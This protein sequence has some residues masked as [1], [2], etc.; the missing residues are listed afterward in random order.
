MIVTLDHPAHNKAGFRA[1]CPVG[2]AMCVLVGLNK[3][4]QEHKPAPFRL[5]YFKA[6]V[7]VE[8][9]KMEYRVYV[10]IFLRELN[11]KNTTIKGLQQAPIPWMYRRVGSLQELSVHQWR[12]ITTTLM[13]DD[14][15]IFDLVDLNEIFGGSMSKEVS[16][17]LLYEVNQLR[18]QA[19]RDM[20]SWCDADWAIMQKILQNPIT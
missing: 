20:Q 3:E 12:G 14:S 16:E 15:P 19:Y 5:E 11:A 2:K 6:N 18:D 8:P 4:G 9:E 17:V 13:M 10:R 1:D 7:E